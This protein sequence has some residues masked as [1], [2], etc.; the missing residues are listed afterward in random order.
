MAKAIIS[1]RRADRSSIS[2]P[3]INALPVA[4][5]MLA[6]KIIETEGMDSWKCS[7]ILG[8]AIFIADKSIRTIKAAML[9]AINKRDWAFIF[10]S[11]DAAK[12]KQLQKT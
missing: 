4:E 9:I 3:I 12:S 1:I 8:K 6:I 10:F 5:S 7:R 11:S 2:F